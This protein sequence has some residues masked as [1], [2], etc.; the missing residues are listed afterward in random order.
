MSVREEPG[1]PQVP[2]GRA[3]QLSSLARLAIVVGLP[4]LSAFVGVPLWFT[5]LLLLGLAVLLFVGPHLSRRSHSDPKQ[6]WMQLM[7][8]FVRL[9]SAY[10]DVQ[11]SPA[12]AVARGQ[13]S[14]LEERCLSL[15]GS[16]ADSD[17]GSD[18]QY[19][20]K[21][22]NE[23]AAMSAEVRAN[24]TYPASTPGQGIDSAAETGKQVPAP[25]L[26][27]AAV[28]TDSPA[29]PVIPDIV[30]SERL[31]DLILASENTVL[32]SGGTM[33]SA[34]PDTPAPAEEQHLITVAAAQ[35]EASHSLPARP[36]IP[37]PSEVQ[38]PTPV[39]ERMTMQSRSPAPPAKL[40]VVSLAGKRLTPYVWLP[41][42]VEGAAAFYLSIFENSL[43]AGVTRYP[44]GTCAP[45]GGVR[46]ATVCLDGQELILLDGGPAYKLP[47]AFSLLVRC[48]NQAEVDYYWQR[49]LSGGGDESMCGWLKDRFGV[50]WQVIPD[51]LL[52]LLND[53][54][55]ER[56]ARATGAMLKMKK[57]DIATLRDAAAR[58]E[59]IT[60]LPHATA[61]ALSA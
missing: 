20:A 47:E 46:S 16:R 3:R 38:A 58:P 54:D 30:T 6:A 17:W 8:S 29:P 49:L 15:L 56:A 4:F 11:Q 41:G 37:T 14:T 44:E 55:P 18:S 9:Q 27:E 35:A 31:L 1:C 40:D 24:G 10:C 45:T 61:P 57:I 5:L 60:R 21:I 25:E 34:R 7:G 12:N 33:S 39:S 2:A 43:V 59:A 19:A 23:I 50:S 52:E 53:P 36:E 22:R 51:A 28:R 13:F 26:K 42:D 32:R 48:A